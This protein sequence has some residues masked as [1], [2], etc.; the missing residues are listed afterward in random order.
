MRARPAGRNKARFKSYV[1]GPVPSRRL[2]LSLGVDLLPFKTCSMDCVYC[3]L[4][5]SGR[6]TARR[7]EYAPVRTVLRQIKAALNSG[8]KI[9]AVTFSGSGEPAL[10]SGIGRVIAGIRR[11]TDAKIVVL[12]NSTCLAGARA[13][14]DLLGANI[15]VPSLD[16]VTPRI[17]AGINRPHAGVTADKI[18]AG[19]AAFRREF[20]GSIWLEVMLVKGLNDGPGHLRA[21]KKAVAR[22]APDRVQLNTVVRP[23]ADKSARPLDRGAL[24]AIRGFLGEKAEIIAPFAGG[25]Q[26]EGPADPGAAILETIQRRPMTAADL[27]ASLGFP[28]EEVLARLRRLEINGL[29]HPVRHGGSDFYE[30]V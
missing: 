23:P 26:T 5:S 12:T 4:G 8:P 2:G 30:P 29:L 13:R 15:V 16:A 6:T 21:L 1:Y 28:L 3:Q 9:D 22:I 19:L 14:R 20:K 27:S 11:L 25:T 10:H 24:E 7:R 17:L 18:I